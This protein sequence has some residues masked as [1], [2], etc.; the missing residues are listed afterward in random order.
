M[1]FK[2]LK[3]D[4]LGKEYSLSIAYVS[5]DKSREINKKYRKKAKPA[6]VLSFS[7]RE[8]EGE[9]VLRK[10]I[11]KKEAKESGKIFSQ[12]LSRLVIYGML[13]SKGMKHSSTMETAEAKYD[14]K[15]FY[16]NRRGN[17]HDQSRGGRVLKGRKKS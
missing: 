2:E 13:H 1:R 17:L 15:Y 14:K 16:R 7:L 9:L 5:E 10:A 3:N 11:I 8:N 6:S 12:W 4:I